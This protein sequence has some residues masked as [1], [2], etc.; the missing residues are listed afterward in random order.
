LRGQYLKSNG[1]TP[2]PYVYED[3]DVDTVVSEFL[4]L[5]SCRAK[6]TAFNVYE[7]LVLAKALVP[8]QF[9]PFAVDGG[10]DYFFVDCSSA[11][12]NVSFFVGD[13]RSLLR[14][15]VGLPEFWARLKQE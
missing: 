8:L 15:S 9:F 10:G 1:G 4:P 13:D 6:R 12:E 5:V 14:L 11:N 3:D 2:D 7:N